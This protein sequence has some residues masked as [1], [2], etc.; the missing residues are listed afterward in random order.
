MHRHGEALAEL[1]EPHE[2][3]AQAGLGVH[4]EVGQAQVLEHVAAQM[5]GLV[6]DEHG[7]LLGLVGKAGDFGLDRVVGRGARALHGEVELPSGVSAAITAVSVRQWCLM[8]SSALG[9]ARPS[10]GTHVSANRTANTAVSVVPRSPAHVA[11]A[12]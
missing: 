10:R 4:G 2:D 1:G 8:R 9:C 6:D 3:E 7:E 11:E 5:L 12:R